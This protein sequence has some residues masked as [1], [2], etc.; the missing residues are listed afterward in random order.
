MK[1]KA[2]ESAKFVKL[3]NYRVSTTLSNYDFDD[4]AAAEKKFKG[5]HESATMWQSVKI[6]RG[7]IR[8]SWQGLR[9]KTIKNNSIKY[10]DY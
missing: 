8:W 10:F 4:E 3:S 7:G 5:L 9:G 2:K 1:K 6:L